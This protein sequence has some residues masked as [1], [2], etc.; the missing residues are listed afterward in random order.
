MSYTILWISLESKVVDDQKLRR[1]KSTG[2]LL[3]QPTIHYS[4]KNESC[5]GVGRPYCLQVDANDE[6][7]CDLFQELMRAFPCL[8]RT[9]GSSNTTT[10]DEDEAN[11]TVWT[12]RLI[13]PMCTRVASRLAGWSARLAVST[14]VLGTN[15]AAGSYSYCHGT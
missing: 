15:L 9:Q 2:D 6:R 5:L 11:R 14:E 13:S 12:E 3:L 1:I 7:G 8:H 10:S 4:M